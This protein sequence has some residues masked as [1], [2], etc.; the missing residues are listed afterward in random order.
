M[1]I[2]INHVGSGIKAM[3]KEGVVLHFILGS[4]H[5]REISSCFELT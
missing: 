5:Y 3:I 4:R 1:C 2:G